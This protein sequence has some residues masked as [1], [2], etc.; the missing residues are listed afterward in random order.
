MRLLFGLLL[1]LVVQIIAY[2]IVFAAAQGGGSFMGLLA[3]PVA[4]IAF[5]VLLIMGIANVRG[6]RPV[7]SIASSALLIAIVPPVLLL[8]VRALES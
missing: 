5:V 7:A 8:I 1:P 6:A 3:M 4:A 2:V